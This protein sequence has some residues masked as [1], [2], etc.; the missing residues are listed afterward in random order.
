M[1]KKPGLL[2]LLIVALLLIALIIDVPALAKFVGFKN[3]WA[4]HKGLDLQGGTHLV[5]QTDLSKVKPGDE[6]DAVVGAV[7]VVR[8]RV[9]ALGVSE[10]LIQKTKDN[11][12]VI[13]ELPGIQ[14]VNQAIALIGQTAQLE[15]R[16]G[17]LD[18]SIDKDGKVVSS[19][20]TLWKDIGLTG[21]HFAKAEPQIDQN[22][23]SLVRK[24]VIAIE[25]DAEGAQLFEDITSRNIGQ[26]V[27]IFLDGIL[28]SA[29][30][31]QEKIGN[32]QAEITGQF[33]V[34]EAKTLVRNLNLG[35]LPVPIHLISSQTIGATLGADALAKG[36][37]AGLLGLAVVAL[38]MIL[39]YRLPGL[40]AVVSLVIYIVLMLALF[41]L[42]PVTLTAAGIAGFIL[43]IGIAIDANVLI[44]ERLKEELRE[45]KSLHEATIDGFTR[46]WLSIRDSNLSS[47]ISAVILFWFG[48][49]MIKG[50]A[51]TMA[52]GIVISM[53]T[54]ITVT[55]TFLLAL[56]A[57]HKTRLVSFLFGSGYKL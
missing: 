56:G 35:A 10:P 21:A 11:S 36:V 14:D 47:L 52:L 1:A 42:I 46:A 6:T 19:D 5:Y 20:Y 16:E 55:R 34:D 49:S 26:P 45:G 27:A 38:L 54:A 7:D 12:R 41:K 9:D 24:P 23:N 28:L 15:F 30:I 29:P 33:S 43:S 48:T 18:K 2:L 25:F 13:I 53:F 3:G 37:Y 17:I 51:F 39:W 32:G 40:V 57:K 8:R 50:F 4:I 31:V 22:S 44:F